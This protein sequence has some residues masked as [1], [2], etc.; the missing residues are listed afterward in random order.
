MQLTFQCPGC[1]QSNHVDVTEASADV[2]CK[3][4]DWKRPVAEGTFAG[5]TPS[6][7]LVCGCHDLWRQKDFPQGVGLAIVILAATLSTIAYAMYHPGLAIVILMVFALADLL[8]YFFKRD[9]LVCYRCH[10]RHRATEISADY[11][12]FNLELNERY[13]Q[14]AIRLRQTPDPR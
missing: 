14:E 2:S 5:K 4:C 3:A 6:C 1:R 11:P 9:V 12:A 8:L 7:C 13:R 10:A